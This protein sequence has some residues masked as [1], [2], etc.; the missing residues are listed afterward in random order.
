MEIQTQL[1]GNM[2][3]I[4]GESEARQMPASPTHQTSRI[5][6]GQPTWGLNPTTKA[7]RMQLWSQTLSEHL[8]GKVQENRD[9]GGNHCDHLETDNLP[10]TQWSM[11]T[12][13]QAGLDSDL[14]GKLDR[15]LDI[16]FGAD[17]NGGLNRDSDE[18][19][20]QLTETAIWKMAQEYA[21]R[22]STTVDLP[23]IYKNPLKRDTGSNESA[24][25]RGVKGATGCGLM[26]WIIAGLDDLG[27]AERAIPID[28]FDYFQN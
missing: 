21:S 28:T 8:W 4:R 23:E 26:V 9:M 19:L 17:L 6:W 7:S 13:F 15:D 10:R 20:N 18:W 25:R 24:I 27:R 22:Y 16:E 5:Y 14:D 1:T 2:M 11:R 12:Q 3:G